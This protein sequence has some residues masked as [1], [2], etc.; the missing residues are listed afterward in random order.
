[1]SKYKF[2]FECEEI[3]GYDSKSCQTGEMTEE[4]YM[5]IFSMIIDGVPISRMVTKRLNRDEE[6]ESTLLVEDTRLKQ[7]EELRQ[8]D[9]GENIDLYMENLALKT[10]IA[11]L[12]EKS[13]G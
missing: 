12:K 7:M 1:M 11:E 10:E 13:D 8:A 3:G 6:W 4:A 9:K 5:H 2:K